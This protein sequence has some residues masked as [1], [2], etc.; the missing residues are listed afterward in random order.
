MKIHQKYLREFT[1]KYPPKFTQKDKF[2]RPREFTK[3]VHENLP[4]LS[5]KIYLLCSVSTRCLPPVFNMEYFWTLECTKNLIWYFREP[6]AYLSEHRETI[7]CHHRRPRKPTVYQHHDLK[8]I[9][10]INQQ[11]TA[12]VAQ[13]WEMK[14]FVCTCPVFEAFRST[15]QKVFFYYLLLLHFLYCENK[16]S[17]QSAHFVSSILIFEM[18]FFH[19]ID[20]KT[21]V[22]F[23]IAVDIQLHGSQLLTG[24]LGRHVIWAM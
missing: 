12:L 7:L 4:T 11:Q 19:S 20:I 24:Y 21:S 10:S 22:R 9:T 8:I 3:S 2:S 5:T 1:K 13:K 16:S 6:L 15:L 18:Y 17:S 14:F 23:F